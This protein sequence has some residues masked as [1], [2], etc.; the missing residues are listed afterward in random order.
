MTMCTATAATSAVAGQPAGRVR[1]VSGRILESDAR[2]RWVSECFRRVADGMASALHP[3]KMIAHNRLELVLR[4]T[5]LNLVLDLVLALLFIAGATGAGITM[6]SALR[7]LGTTPSASATP[8]ASSRP[9][10]S[11]SIASCMAGELPRTSC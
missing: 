11:P 2:G 3:G 10:G 7:Q 8:P 4:R 6:K 5:H 9:A 1:T